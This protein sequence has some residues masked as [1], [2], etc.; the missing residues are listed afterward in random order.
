L[1]LAWIRF[2]YGGPPDTLLATWGVGFVLQQAVRL[3]FGPDLKPLSLPQSLGG[4]LD[5]TAMGMTFPIYRLFIIGV[6]ALCVIGLYLLWSRTGF[7]FKVGAV[8]QNRAMAASLGIS[9]RRVN[10]VRLLPATTALSGYSIWVLSQRMP[11]AELQGD[12]EVAGIKLLRLEEAES[13]GHDPLTIFLAIHSVNDFNFGHTAGA[14][15]LPD[16]ETEKWLP[17]FK[18]RLERTRALIV[19]CGSRDCGK[20]LWTAIR[21]RNAGLAQT[22]IFPDG[23]NEWVVHKLPTVG[24][25]R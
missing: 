6:T 17:E 9:T 24:A 16:E 15:S 2:L 10:F 1:R 8:T 7:G 22:V 5:W 3:V 20:S 21:M 13:L 23:W 11:R 25:G 12:G 18:P 14:I 19:Y 4:S